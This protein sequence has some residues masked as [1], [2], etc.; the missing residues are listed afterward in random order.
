MSVIDAV[1]EC[2]TLGDI[3]SICEPFTS[4]QSKFFK[5]LEVN[6]DRQLKTIHSTDTIN[7]YEYDIV[8]V[9][10]N[11]PNAEEYWNNLKKRFPRAKRVDGVKGIHNAH[12]AAAKLANTKMVWIVDGDAVIAKNFNF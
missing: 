8:M 10:Y 3:L 7:E 5:S 6:P 4:E 9:T 1:N 11:E 2:K 12:V